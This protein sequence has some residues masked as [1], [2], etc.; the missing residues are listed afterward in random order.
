MIYVLQLE[1]VG[2]TEREKDPILLEVFWV[3]RPFKTNK[4]NFMQSTE[5]EVS[6]FSRMSTLKCAQV[7]AY[8]AGIA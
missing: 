5:E 3:M 7:S 2:S 8:A 6:A 1:T 4:L